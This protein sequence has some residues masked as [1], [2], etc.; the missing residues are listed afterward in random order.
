MRGV[1]PSEGVGVRISLDWPPRMRMRRMMTMS[2]L[3]RE[4]HHLAYLPTPW[5]SVVGYVYLVDG[6]G[7]A[8]I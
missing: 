2:P 3:L 7:E 1:C 4:V 6:L 8:I 5:W